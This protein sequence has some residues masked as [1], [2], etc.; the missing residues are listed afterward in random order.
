MRYLSYSLSDNA[1]EKLDDHIQ[2]RYHVRF[3]LIKSV[4]FLMDS[5]WDESCDPAMEDCWVKITLFGGYVCMLYRNTATRFFNWF[6]SDSSD[7]KIFNLDDFPKDEVSV[8][9]L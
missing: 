5:M 1:T 3:D 4:E 9:E 8:Y 2:E 6:R 7:G